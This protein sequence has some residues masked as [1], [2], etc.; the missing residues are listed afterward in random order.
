ML[1]EKKVTFV[2]GWLPHLSCNNNDS[3][4]YDSLTTR[5]EFF[6]RTTCDAVCLGARVGSPNAVVEV[7]TARGAAGE[8]GPR[9]ELVPTAE[10]RVW[11]GEVSTAVLQ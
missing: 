6:S 3:C 9:P 11:R 1:G 10:K 4:S 7:Q 8:P 5:L 2:Y